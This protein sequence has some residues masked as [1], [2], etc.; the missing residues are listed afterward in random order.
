MVGHQVLVLSIEVRVLVPQ[1]K[2]NAK[3]FRWGTS[4]VLNA[5]YGGLE[6]KTGIQKFPIKIEFKYFYWEF[7]SVF[8][9]VEK[10]SVL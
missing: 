8:P 4:N 9:G 3:L 2:E 10:L 1:Q 6:R 5:H 7:L